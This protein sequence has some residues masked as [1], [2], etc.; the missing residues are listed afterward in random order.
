MMKDI[1]ESSNGVKLSLYADD[2]SIWK[3]GRNIALLNRDIQLHLD[4]ITKFFNSLGLVISTAKTVVILFTRNNRA[5]VSAVSLKVENTT[6]TVDK[7]VKFLEV[8]FDKTFSWTQRIDYVI[9][10]CKG[11]L[12]LMRCMSGTSFGAGK[13]TPI[14]I[15]KALI[16]SIIDY[17]SIGRSPNTSHHSDRSDGMRKNQDASTMSCN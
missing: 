13:E 2:S 10:R 3:I 15:Y 8:I 9:D 6:L 17:E 7:E 16:S 12:N 4:D 5:D 11:R 1:P 14:I